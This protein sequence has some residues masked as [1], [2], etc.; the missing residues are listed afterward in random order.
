MEKYLNSF[1]FFSKEEIAEVS[2]IG[3]YQEIKKGE[4]FFK[5]DKICEQVTFVKKG[6]FR[7]FYPLD[8]GE[9]VTYC[10]TFFDN[11]ITA[12]SYIK[13]ENR[14]LLLQKEKARANASKWF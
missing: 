1:G 7:H 13:R 11:F 9:E 4:F 3:T 14:I 8:S 6:I 12:Y 5:G 10:F 2:K